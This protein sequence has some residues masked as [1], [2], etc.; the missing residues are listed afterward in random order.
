[1]A[2]YKNKC[3]NVSIYKHIS[4]YAYVY[5]YIYIYIY[6]YYIYI[7]IYYIYIRRINMYVC[8]HNKCKINSS[9]LRSKSI[10]QDHC[11]RV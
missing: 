10:F 6:I 7:Y 3:K 2:Q 5:V 9:D 1:M 8:M 11:S 4:F